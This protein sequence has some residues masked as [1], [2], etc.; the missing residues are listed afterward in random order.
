MGK[1]NLKCLLLDQDP[2]QWRTSTNC[3]EAPIR[4]EIRNVTGTKVQTTGGRWHDVDNEGMFDVIAEM[5]LV[6]DPESRIEVDLIEE[7]PVHPK[8]PKSPTTFSP[9]YVTG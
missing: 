7:E 2:P 9:E 4:I 5:I 1:T 8:Q 6:A 3:A